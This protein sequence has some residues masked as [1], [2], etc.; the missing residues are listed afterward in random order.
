MCQKHVFEYISKIERIVKEGM[1][2]GQI[3]KGNA[4]V[5]ASEIYALIASTLVYK[6]KSQENVEI[7][8]L[9][10]ELEN[11]VIEGIK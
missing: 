1:E 9:Y 7:I 8:K 4:N 3:K 5:I 6:M 10:K 2:A 11:T